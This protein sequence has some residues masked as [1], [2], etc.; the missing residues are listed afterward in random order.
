MDWALDHPQF[1]YYTSGRATPGRDE[2]DFTTAPQTSRLFGRC[3][4][5]LVVSADEALGHPSPFTL[6]EGGA[7]EGR[8]ARDVLDAL[9]ERA[10]GLYQRLLY[11]PEDVSAVWRERQTALLA[12]HGS[13]LAGQEPDGFEGLYL[14]N[15]LVDAFPVHRLRRSRGQL[16][17]L[18]VALDGEGFVE[19]EGPPSRPELA[20]QLEMDGIDLADGCEAEVNLRAG[21][22]LSAA[23]R[24]LTRGFVVTLDYGD[25][26]SRL[27]GP[28]RPRGTCV[29][30]RHHRL[31]DDLLADPGL[32]DL[33][34]HVNFSALSRAGEEAGLVAAPLESQREFLFS[35]GLADEVEALEHAGLS[36][37][38]VLEARRALAPLLFPGPAGSDSFR[39]LLQGKGIPPSRLTR[40][41]L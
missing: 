27:Y 12:P 15:E 16:R 20:L 26:G 24:R 8:L 10:P 29:G 13:R 21:E 25:T 19:K 18:Y 41:T 28:H 37:V 36:D 1:G 23:A 34:A 31:T 38:D 7:G 14:S 3:L 6:V 17:E 4:A 35:F 40:T 30:Y 11:H 22:W 5:R 39:V 2:G 9:A 32:Q 33:T